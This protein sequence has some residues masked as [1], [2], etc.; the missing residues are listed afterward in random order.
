M[1][2]QNNVETSYFAIERSTLYKRSTVVKFLRSISDSFGDAAAETDR[3]CA[4]LILASSN[5]FGEDVCR[6]TAWLCVDDCRGNFL[7][8]FSDCLCI[9]LCLLI[10]C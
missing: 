9:F 10:D 3:R 4:A 8:S 6:E 5:E 2:K 1:G 7:A